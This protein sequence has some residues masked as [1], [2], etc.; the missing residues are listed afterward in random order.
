MNSKLWI[1]LAALALMGVMASSSW[2]VP[3]LQDT[4]TDGARTNGGDAIDADW[5]TTRPETS[6]TVGPDGTLGS[7]NALIV[8]NTT[9]SAG[10][11]AGFQDVT[12]SEDR[13]KIVLTFDY[14]LTTFGNTNGGFRYGIL[15]DGG[16]PRTGD[17]AG[18]LNDD[19]GYFVLTDT[20]TGTSV[21][22]I[23]REPGTSG[24]LGGSDAFGSG[25]NLGG[26]ARPS[27][28]DNA[29]HHAAFTVQRTAAG[30]ID[31][32][33]RI[34][35][36]VTLGQDVGLLTSTFNEIG[37]VGGGSVAD[38]VLDN[39]TVERRI[40]IFDDTFASSGATG[41]DDANDPN[42]T[43]WGNTNGGVTLTVGNNAAIG[44]GD[45]LSVVSSGRFKNILTSFTDV[46]LG[47]GDK[48]IAS[49]DATLTAVEN[50]GSGFRFGLYDDPSSAVSNEGYFVAVGTGTS[51]GL[52]T[53]KDPSTG[54]SL[55]GGGGTPTLASDPSFNL[56]ESLAHYYEWVV[57]RTGDDSALLEL[58][59]DGV[60]VQTAV[61]SSGAFDQFG[62]FGFATGGVSTDFVID[63]VVIDFVPDATVPEPTTAVLGLMGIAGLV[64]RRRRAA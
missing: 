28:N 25:T 58:F 7:G 3:V 22:D 57:T 32:R 53:A 47:I 50:S 29:A 2:A 30:R 15:N 5:F 27:T 35:T 9:T 8:D 44:S 42:D 63:N 61:D 39:V 33:N 18:N 36:V 40:N 12:L 43:A 38:I 52:V 23:R 34:G 48:L 56:D 21:D 46:E 11:V 20:G 62:A 59:M 6:A 31:L 10:V 41:G 45:A 19:L 49:F 14:R 54:G 1:P 4:F 16:T 55:F 17:N 24:L 60:L 64:T 13:E 37:L 26:S 51:N